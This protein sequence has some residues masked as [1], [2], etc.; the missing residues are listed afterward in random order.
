MKRKILLFFLTLMVSGFGSTAVAQFALK[1]NIVDDALLNVNL[2]AELRTAP[3]WSFDLSGSLNAWTLNNGKRWRH[4]WVM[5][6]A[7][8]WFCRTFGG[9]FVAAHLVGGNYNIGMLD[10]DFSFLGTDF[11]KLKD[12]RYQGWGVGAGIGYGYRWVLGRHWDIEAEFGFGW[13]YTR[14]DIFECVDCGRKVENN[15]VHN[16]VGPTKVAVNLVYNF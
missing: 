6:E 5:P 7:R 2:G 13:V 15:R 9:H 16:Y 3:Q 11:G 1:T 14:S 4:W 10:T 8:Y 12:Y